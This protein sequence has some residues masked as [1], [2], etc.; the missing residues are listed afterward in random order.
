[1]NTPET[2]SAIEQA[3]AFLRG[4]ATADLRF[5]EHLRPIKYVITPDGQLAA[6][7]MVAMLQAVDTVLFV[8][9]CSEDAMELLV[10]LTQFDERGS[11]GAAA[12]RWRIYHGE[13]EDVRWAFM[14]I[15]TARFDG[16][17]IDGGALMRSNPL[18]ADEAR[19]CRHMNQDHVDDLRLLCKRFAAF[20]VEQPVMVGIDPLGIDVRARFDILRVPATE[21]MH[22]PDD[23]RRVLTAMTEMAKQ[24]AS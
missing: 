17:V 20:E 14:S 8:P 15:D 2:D 5:D 19:I 23:A 1:M 24:N 22:T 6:P 3:Y 7:V 10:T 16:I 4:H 21:P 11:A 18:A 13:P 12:D 9:D